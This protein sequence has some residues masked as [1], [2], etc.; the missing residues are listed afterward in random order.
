M[1]IPPFLFSLLPS[2]D[3]ISFTNIQKIHQCETFKNSPIRVGEAERS[4]AQ[5]LLQL[6]HTILQTTQSL[7]QRATKEPIP[8]GF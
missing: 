1:Q 5:C 6:Q 4:P 2:K 7:Y 8:T 3:F